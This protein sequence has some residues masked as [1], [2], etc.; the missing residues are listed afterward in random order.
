[1]L[2]LESQSS[3]SLLPGRQNSAQHQTNPRQLLRSDTAQAV[4]VAC[5]L[6]GI[7]N[8]H[9]LMLMARPC[10]SGLYLLGAVA[11]SR[12][13][14]QAGLAGTCFLPVRQ[15]RLGLVSLSAQSYVIQAGEAPVNVGIASPLSGPSLSALFAVL[16]SGACTGQWSRQVL[17]SRRLPLLQPALLLLDQGGLQAPSSRNLTGWTWS[18]GC[19]IEAS[20]GEPGQPGI[21]P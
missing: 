14:Q 18:C 21:A 5:L 12:K 6:S 8:I 17:S 4:N 3:S 13:Q 2:V 1:M 7:S 10:K 20:Q 19:C 11:T 16:Y 9:E 15:S